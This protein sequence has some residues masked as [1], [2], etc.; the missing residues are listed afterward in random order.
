MKWSRKMK[1]KDKKRKT[2]FFLR[3]RTGLSRELMDRFAGGDP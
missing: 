3:M 2:G 1:G